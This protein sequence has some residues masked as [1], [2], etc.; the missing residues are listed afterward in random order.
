LGDIVGNRLDLQAPYAELMKEIGLPWYNVMGNHDMNMDAKAD[1]LADETFELNFGPATYSFNV[2]KVHFIILDDIIYPS[3]TPGRE[4]WGGFTEKQF[5][6]LENDLK[7][8]PKDNMVILSMHIPLKSARDAF[9]MEDRKRLFTSLKDF[10]NCLALSAHTHLQRNDFLGKKEDWFQAKSLHEFNAGTTSGDWYSGKLNDKG[11]PSS[12][13][14]DGTRKGYAFLN[15]SG[16]Q[17]SI[18]YKVAGM[19][20]D[21][22]MEVYCPKVI[23]TE[24]NTARFFANYFMGSDA[25]ILEYKFNEGDW[26]KMNFTKSV[27]PS[28]AAE[29]M[30]WDFTDTLM[31]GRRP[32]NGVEST[33]LWQAS[34]PKKM[35]AGNYTLSIRVTDRY[36]KT[37]TAQKLFK[38]EKSL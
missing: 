10:P 21:Y 14:R 26:Q 27:D 6:F 15:I 37:H 17:Y 24:K 16:I 25:D 4:Y 13:M 9:R 3:P 29:L 1:S 22:Q 12:T 32:S 19:P 11:V 28:F 35:K 23:S 18:E 36:G 30:Q 2:G 7:L 31:N 33:H 20:A 34:F 38:V 5:T 8:V